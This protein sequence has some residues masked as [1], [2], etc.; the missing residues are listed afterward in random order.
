MARCAPPRKS[1]QEIAAGHAGMIDKMFM[2]CSYAFMLSTIA[3]GDVQSSPNIWQ[4]KNMVT[5]DGT[6]A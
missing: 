5:I 4:K 3:G 2:I 6:P 1:W